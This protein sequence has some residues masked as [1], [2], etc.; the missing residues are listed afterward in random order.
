MAYIDYIL[1]MAVTIH[2]E[3]LTIWDLSGTDRASFL[4]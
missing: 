3:T 4:K 1:S 2:K